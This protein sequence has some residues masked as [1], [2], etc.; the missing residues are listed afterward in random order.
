M[1]NFT[2]IRGKGAKLSYFAQ[3]IH[4]YYIGNT[5]SRDEVDVAKRRTVVYGLHG[6]P[7]PIELVTQ[8]FLLKQI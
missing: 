4:W 7:N 5:Y 8:L 1:K 6:I 3:T 2:D